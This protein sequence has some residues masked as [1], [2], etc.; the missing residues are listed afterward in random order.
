MF[1]RYLTTL[2]QMTM[3]HNVE[4]YSSNEFISCEKFPV[5]SCL[6]TLASLLINK[7]KRQS[8]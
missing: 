3:L 1:L 6:Y 7:T 4:M 8:R 5:S 2:F